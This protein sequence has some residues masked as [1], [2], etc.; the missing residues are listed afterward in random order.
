MR[1]C[2]SVDRW[3]IL[4]HF[5]RIRLLNHLTKHPAK[6][7]E[8]LYSMKIAL[9]LILDSMLMIA[10]IYAALNYDDITVKHAVIG[11]SIGLVAGLA[12]CKTLRR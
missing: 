7:R 2:G 11:A 5:S 8:K 4:L 12:H 1:R 6:V 9:I 3:S 10:L